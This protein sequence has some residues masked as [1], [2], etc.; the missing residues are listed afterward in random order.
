[1]ESFKNEFENSPQQTFTNSKPVVEPTD[2]CWMWIVQ[3]FKH[4]SFH[5]ATVNSEK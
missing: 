2:V 3:Y 1:M 4:A 5:F